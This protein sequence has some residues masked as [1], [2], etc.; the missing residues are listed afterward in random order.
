MSDQNGSENGA[1]STCRWIT[2]EQAAVALDVS[3]KTVRRRVRAGKIGARKVAGESGGFVWE[4]AADATGQPMAQTDSPTDSPTD[5]PDTQAIAQPMAQPM[6]Q[7]ANLSAEPMAQPMAQVDNRWPN[8][9]DKMATDGPSGQSDR[10]KQADGGGRVIEILERENAFLK[11][12]IEAQRLQI[13]AVNRSNAEISAALREALK[14][15]HRALTS[16]AA[17]VPSGADTRG[18][19][20][21]AAP[22]MQNQSG[23]QVLDDGSDGATQTGEFRAR[24]G[25][26]IKAAGHDQSGPETS[27]TA[28]ESTT[29]SGATST[30]A[31]TYKRTRG[32]RGWLLQVL[33]GR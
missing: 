32:F 23:P 15:S 4:I 9:W 11:S 7:N 2:T 3:A 1:A 13:E 24:D 19:Q 10:T 25:A 20:V 27:G 28:R 8:R 26:T 6:G 29:E 17:G 14:M 30:S 33:A 31:S 5:R 21:L 12:Q 22:E 16:G 18:P